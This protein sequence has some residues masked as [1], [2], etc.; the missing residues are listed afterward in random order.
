V[1]KPPNE[2]RVKHV[3]EYLKSWRELYV[4]GRRQ[5]DQS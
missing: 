2:L 4:A 1:K 3:A 5:L